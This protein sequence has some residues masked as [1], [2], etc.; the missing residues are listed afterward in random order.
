[1]DRR[2]ATSRCAAQLEERMDA[3]ALY[4][5]VRAAALRYRT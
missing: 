1:M 5:H 4:L 3:P 2:A